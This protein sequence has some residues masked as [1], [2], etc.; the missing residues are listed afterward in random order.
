MFSWHCQCWI[1][2]FTSFHPIV[3]LLQSEEASPRLFF[4]RHTSNV[5]SAQLR[6]FFVAKIFQFSRNGAKSH[7]VTHLAWCGI[8]WSGRLTN[9]AQMYREEHDHST[10]RRQQLIQR[11]IC[12]VIW[13][14]R[15]SCFW[16][17]DQDYQDF[18]RLMSPFRSLQITDTLLKT[19]SADLW[20]LGG[21]PCSL[22][23]SGCLSVPITSKKN[24]VV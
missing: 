6:S 8:K 19:L 11:W 22:M 4:V 15:N 16:N 2:I 10:P 12:M 21:S 9:P 24:L 5:L 13:V 20:R 23:P 3:L 7:I 17:T 18:E 1:L 14:R